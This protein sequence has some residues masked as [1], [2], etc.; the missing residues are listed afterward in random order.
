MKKSSISIFIPALN[1]EKHLENSIKMILATIGERFTD[2]EILLFNDGSSDHTAA[3]ADDLAAWNSHIRVFHNPQ[4]MGV[5]YNYL[6]AITEARMEYFTWTTGDAI[7]IYLPEDLQRLLDAVG[8]AD[9]V[10][11]YNHSDA[12]PFFRR[13]LSQGYPAI[14]NLLFGL[15][16]HYYHGINV[17][18]TA[19]IKQIRIKTKGVVSIAEIVIR[20]IRSGQTYVE[21]GMT[22]LDDGRN[23][24]QVQLVNFIEVGKNVL[25]LWWELQ[26]KSRFVSRS[27]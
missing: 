10:V 19:W 18:R 13:L 16:L 11:Y 23:S 9:V 12:R 6:R 4:R 7:T 3:I 14:M 27:S 22:N 21:V 24:K 1:E 5:G 8:K 17:Y 26:I 15:H 25:S 2:F 20:A